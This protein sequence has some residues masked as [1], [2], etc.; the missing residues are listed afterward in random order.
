MTLALLALA[1]LQMGPLPEMVEGAE[2]R[3]VSRDLLAVHATGRIE[4]GVMR[5]EGPLEPGAELRMLVFA[6]HG[7]PDAESDEPRDDAPKESGGWWA[8]VTPDGRDLMFREATAP[9]EEARSL[10][11]YL[12]REFGVELVLVRDSP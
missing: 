2:V 11:T 8:R 10:R 12:R 4:D 9:P 1:A 3:L 7:G 6:A 5:L